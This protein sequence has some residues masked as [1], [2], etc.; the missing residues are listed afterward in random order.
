MIV[1]HFVT[2]VQAVDSVVVYPEKMKTTDS[3]GERLRFR[4]DVTASV[5]SIAAWE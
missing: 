3:S 5:F 1:K 2:G 4:K